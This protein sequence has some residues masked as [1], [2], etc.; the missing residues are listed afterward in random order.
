MAA[1]STQAGPRTTRLS[2]EASPTNPRTPAASLGVERLNV[3]LPLSGLNLPP[4]QSPVT[5]PPSTARIQV[6]P[7]ANAAVRLTLGR[8]NLARS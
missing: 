5:G 7:K 3:G 4:V 6:P 1:R 2:A 8:I